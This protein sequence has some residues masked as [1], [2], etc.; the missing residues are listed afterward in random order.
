M[1]WTGRMERR[2]LKTGIAETHIR[3]PIS[4]GWTIERELTS[5]VRPRHRSLEFE[6]Q[7]LTISEWSKKAGVPPGHIRNRLHLGWTIERTLTEPVMSAGR[8]L[9]ERWEVQNEKRQGV[10]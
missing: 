1:V 10:T 5:K 9:S 3:N 4:L 8:P 7:N 6:N 2:T